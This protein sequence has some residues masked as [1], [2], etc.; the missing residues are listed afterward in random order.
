M[1]M[2]FRAGIITAS[3]IAASLAVPLAA[4]AQP[5]S[6]PPAVPQGRLHGIVMEIVTTTVGVSRG[7]VIS[8][9]R[10]GG[11]IAD[12]AADN[13]SSGQEVVDAL[14]VVVEDHLDL[15]LAEG[16]IDEAK[17][18][19]IRAARLV[20]F[21]SLVFE[22]HDGPADGRFGKPGIGNGGARQLLVNT[23]QETL[24]INHGQL[25]SHIRTGGTLAELA[26]ENGSSGPELEAALV[27][28]VDARLDQAVAYSDIDE[29]RAAELL[30]KAVTRIGEM[31]YKVYQPGNGR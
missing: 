13:G 14:M 18:D 23:I 1:F 9:V 26:E 27:A 6:T 7:D 8:Q 3:L 30:E 17:A 15:A 25:L 29:D 2:R 10:T 5:A 22:T 4:G 11:T 21:T 31:V 16:R 20:R 19:E 28:A 12:L 24:D